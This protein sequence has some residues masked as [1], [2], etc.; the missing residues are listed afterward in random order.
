VTQP[1]RVTDGN[2]VVAGDSLSDHHGRIAHHEGVL[3][4][5]AK[6]DRA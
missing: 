3:R 6:N 1:D 5:V 4:Y 2:V